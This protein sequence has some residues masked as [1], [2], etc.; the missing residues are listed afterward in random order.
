M[1]HGLSKS[2]LFIIKRVRALDHFV[3]I[4]ITSHYNS[5]YSSWYII[6]SDFRDLLCLLP[7]KSLGVTHLDRISISKQIFSICTLLFWYKFGLIYAG[8][9]VNTNNIAGIYE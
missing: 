2:I 4:A 3:N 7:L 1:S 5:I 9:Y 6:R 8:L